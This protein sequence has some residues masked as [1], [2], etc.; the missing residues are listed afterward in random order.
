MGVGKRI[1]ALCLALLLSTSM[2][3]TT[4]AEGAAEESISNT[5][6]EMPVQPEEKTEPE[7]Y[8]VYRKK[9]TDTARPQSAVALDM[10]AVQIGVDTSASLSTDGTGVVLDTETGELSWTFQVS[11]AGLYNL[12]FVY[13]TGVTRHSKVNFSAMLD[14]AVP[15]EEWERLT[16]VRP[17]TY[18]ATGT[19]GFVKDDRGNDIQPEQELSTEKVTA[20]LKDADGK[21]NDPLCV[22]MS[23][24]EHTLTLTFTQAVL[25]IYGLRFHPAA[26]LEDYKT[27]Y[28]AQQAAGAQDTTGLEYVIRAERFEQKSDA[29][30]QANYDKSSAATDPAAPSVMSLNILGGVNWQDN[31]QWVE[32]T[33]TVEESGFYNLSFRARQNSKYGMNVLR[34]ILID[35][36]VPFAEL[37]PQS[38]P[39]KNGW[40]IQTLGGETPY[41]FYFEAGVEHTLRME[42][43]S[44]DYENV[45][46]ELTDALTDLNALYRNVVMVTGTSPDDL[47]DYELE[48]SI[49]DLMSRLERLNGILKEQKSHLESGL[50][51][52]GSETSYLDALIVQM[53]GFLEDSETIPYRLDSFKTNISSLA[54]WIATL[55]EQPLELDSIIVHS[56]DTLTVKKSAGFFAETWY[57]LQVIFCSFFKDYGMIGDYA[58]DGKALDVWMNLGRDQLQVLKGMVDSSF[59]PNQGVAVN[60]SLVPGGLIEAVLAGKGPDVALYIGV[61]D[62]VNLAA[63]NA[64]TPLSDFADFEEVSRNFY[65][66]NLIPYQ[67]KDKV[68]ALPCTAEFPMM[69]V[70]TDVLAELGLAIPKTWDDMIDTAAVLQRKNLQI[71]IPSGAAGSSGLYSTFLIQRGV[72][73]YNEARTATRFH[74]ESAIDAFTMFTDFFTKYD[75]PLSY[76]FFNR[77]RT[78]EM[79]IGIDSYTM[80]NYLAA[81]A[82][83]LS[84][85]WT[86][87]PVPATRSEDGTLCDTTTNLNSTAAII[88]KTDRKDDAWTFVK[89]FVSAETQG[90]FGVGI[91][92]RLGASGRYATANKEALELLPW[93]TAQ[94]DALTAQWSTVTEMG[95]IPATYIVERNLSNAFKKVVYNRK[96]AREVLTTYAFTINQEIARKNQ[97]LDKRA[98]RG[99]K[100]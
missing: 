52:G 60:L 10:A 47:R 95:I 61:A 76:N 53:E 46:L 65:D 98:E 45:I 72:T 17:Y 3:M 79:P 73:Y 8:A 69:F 92:A 19:D 100:G 4:A 97:E 31:G 43:V 34:R 55:S 20:D 89:W 16:L 5:V 59:A 56:P 6:T 11:E 21:F 15:Y 26:V 25:T 30:I 51:G 39:Y 41:R 99:T 48:V 93:T 88:L 68:Y 80:Y 87:A 49:P 28:A 38:F 94:V 82:P 67:Y 64:V 33:F 29:G 58:A 86:M 75:F 62:P 42:I 12:E 44:G 22:Y 18:A 81:A 1:M 78:G 54:D 2:V 36:S 90:D 57:S 74:E 63:R 66:D 40:Y 14:G 70:R 83:E 13:A 7:R 32:W 91:E 24:G 9:Y 96:N 77:F 50:I 84:G 71:G 35:D 37:D 27:V 85:L 23:A